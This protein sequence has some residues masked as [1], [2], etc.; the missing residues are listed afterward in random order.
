MMSQPCWIAATLAAAVA[1]FRSEG[2][3]EGRS[4][5]SPRY[6]FREVPTSVGIEQRTAVEAAS[7]SREDRFLRM[8]RPR[9]QLELELSPNNS[10]PVNLRKSRMSSRFPS[11]VLE[12]PTPGSTM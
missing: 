9:W 11:A 6:D 2:C 4:I 7:C 12:N 3:A 8:Y 10:E 1:K 5:N